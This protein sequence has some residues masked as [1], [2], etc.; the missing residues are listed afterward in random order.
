MDRVDLDRETRTERGFFKAI[1]RGEFHIR[2]D[3]VREGVDVDG[4]G[5]EG[6]APGLEQV[7]EIG[8]VALAKKGIGTWFNGGE[9]FFQTGREKS[10]RLQETD[11]RRNAGGA[12]S[13]SG[14]GC[15]GNGGER[16]TMDEGAA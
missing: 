7:V 3:E 16:D 9:E 12:G 13:R 14:S 4:R 11:L 2:R 6:F 10:L 8:G 1:E 5:E 15:R